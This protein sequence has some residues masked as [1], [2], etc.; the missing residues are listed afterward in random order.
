MY[1]HDIYKIAVDPISRLVYY[2]GRMS[3]S[4]FD[5]YIAAVT[6]EGHHNFLL[7][8]KRGNSISNI[9]LDPKAG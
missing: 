8:T 9:A 5:N 1:D 2:T 4:E 7:V 6:F 3:Y